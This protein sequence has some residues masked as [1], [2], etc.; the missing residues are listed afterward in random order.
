MFTSIRQ[1]CA[2]E[3]DSDSFLICFKW[4]KDKSDNWVWDW[5]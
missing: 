4:N 5:K 2:I 3:H 1:V